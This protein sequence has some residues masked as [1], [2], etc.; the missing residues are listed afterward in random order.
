VT[1]KQALTRLKVAGRFLKHV[2]M[3]ALAVVQK[4]VNQPFLKS[5]FAHLANDMLN[6]CRGLPAARPARVQPR[7][8]GFRLLNHVLRTIHSANV[9]HFLNSRLFFDEVQHNIPVR[10]ETSALQVIGQFRA[11][12][13]YV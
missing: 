1:F 7:E 5:A 12:Q 13:R 3:W 8:I 6:V 11:L 9:K 2:I 10:M 4:R